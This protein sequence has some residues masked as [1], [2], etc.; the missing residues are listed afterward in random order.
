MPQFEQTIR[1]YKNL[2]ILQMATWIQSV[3]SA[4]IKTF[5]KVSDSSVW[6]ANKKGDTGDTERA[7]TN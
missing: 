7:Q 3:Q 1:L 4:K 6:G 2:R 5:E